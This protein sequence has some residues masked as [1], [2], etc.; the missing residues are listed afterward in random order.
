MIAFLKKKRSHGD[1]KI[2]VF[3]NACFVA[4]IKENLM[5]IIFHIKTLAWKSRD[6]EIISF[7]LMLKFFAVSRFIETVA[8]KL[9]I[10]CY[11]LKL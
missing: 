4:Y 9:W 11:L 1:P 7:N 8:L 5:L 10:Y 2:N 6:F 3:K